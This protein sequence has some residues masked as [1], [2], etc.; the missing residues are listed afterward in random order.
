MG[1]YLTGTVRKNGISVSK[2][3]TSEEISAITTAGLR[4]FAIYQDGGA[5]ATY[6]NYSKGYSDAQKAYEAAKNLR[7]PLDEIIY[8]A[9]DYDFTDAQTLQSLYRIFKA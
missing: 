6:F 5:S 3:L 9:V 1:R 8:F 2:A 7:I 4:I